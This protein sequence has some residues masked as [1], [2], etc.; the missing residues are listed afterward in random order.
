MTCKAIDG[1]NMRSIRARIERLEQ[2]PHATPGGINW[3]NLYRGP[4]DIVPDG[5]IDW[6]A[7]FGPWEAWSAENCPFERAIAEV[8][9]SASKPKSE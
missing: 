2:R 9:L 8:A 6:E 5:I 3:D 7:L 4:E 1:G